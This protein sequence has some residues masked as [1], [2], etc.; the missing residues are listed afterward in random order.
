MGQC[1]QRERVG[2]APGLIEFELRC[3]NEAVLYGKC[4]KH[5]SK[6][7]RAVLE[8]LKDTEELLA[9]VWGECPRLLDEDSGGTARLDVSLRRSIADVK[10]VGEVEKTQRL[11]EQEAV[12]WIS[13][14]DRLP[15]PSHNFL[16][17]KALEKD[18]SGVMRYRDNQWEDICSYRKTPYTITHW[19]PLPSPPK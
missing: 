2:N 10:E 7:D 15:P 5:L 1:I 19:M 14:N 8:L 16:I 6:R 13:C 4:K 3:K 18:T 9:L 12:T 11:E 17:V